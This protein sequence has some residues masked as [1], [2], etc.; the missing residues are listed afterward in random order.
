MTQPAETSDWTLDDLSLLV[1]GGFLE[2]EDDRTEEMDPLRHLLRGISCQLIDVIV[3]F[4]S[5]AFAGR[6]TP[7]ARSQL[8]GASGSLK[9]LAEAT[10]DEALLGALLALEGIVPGHDQLGGRARERFVRDMHDWITR[11]AELLPTDEAARLR[12]LV[13]LDRAAA[14]L[15]DEIAAVR[16]IGPKRLERLYC[17]GLFTVEVVRAASPRDIALVTGLPMA[18]AEKVVEAARKFG[19]NQRDRVATELIGRASEARN[20]LGRLRPNDPDRPLLV[21]AAREAMA[22]LARALATIDATHEQ[23]PA[24]TGTESR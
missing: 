4:A 18:L 19:D 21:A 10:H 24:L 15:L 14:P 7:T 13:K 6:S 11:F 3:A 1:G 22:E 20:V 5:Q 9:R 17:A 23:T 2:E 8:E 12:S 16:G